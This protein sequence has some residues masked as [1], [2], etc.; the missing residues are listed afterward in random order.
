MLRPPGPSQGAKQRR[1]FTVQTRKQEAALPDAET[2]VPAETIIRDTIKSLLDQRGAVG[3]EVRAESTLT[4]ELGLDS[5]E[6]A[7]LSAVLEDELGH[8]PFSEGIVPETVA[9]LVE[10]YNR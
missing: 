5:L 3:I 6:L 7:E 9:E 1:L 4:A 2:T 8:D 10:Y